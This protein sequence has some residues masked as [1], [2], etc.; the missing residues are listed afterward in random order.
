MRRRSLLT[1]PIHP[2]SCFPLAVS[3]ADIRLV[4]CVGEGS[5]GEVSEDP[6]QLLAAPVPAAALAGGVLD[7]AVAA[8][9]R[10]PVPPH[11]PLCVRL[12]AGVVG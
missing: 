2:P 10:L 9:P 7:A 4:E 12:P 5:F 8:P 11:S 6:A 1:L 3:P